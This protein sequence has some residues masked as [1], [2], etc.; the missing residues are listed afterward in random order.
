M[1]KGS[2]LVCLVLSI[3][4]V[5]GASGRRFITEDD[6]LKFTWIA[7]PQISPDGTT[8]AFVRVTVNERDNKYESALYSVPAAGGV[9]PARI[10]GG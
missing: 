2:L 6:L 3:V 9:A 5:P 10:T 7:D 4:S 8:V 1:K